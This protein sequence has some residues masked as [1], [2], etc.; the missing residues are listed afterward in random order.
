MTQISF[1]LDRL[2][3][4]YRNAT[5]TPTAVVAEVFRRIDAA[6]DDAVWI[7]RRAPDAVFAEAEALVRRQ[8]EIDRLPLFGIPFAVKD[9]IDIKGRRP[10]WRVPRLPINRASPHRSSINYWR[11]ARS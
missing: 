5:I 4:A 2:R 7:S 9:S 1:D 3:G 6:G 10:R 11:L 8:S